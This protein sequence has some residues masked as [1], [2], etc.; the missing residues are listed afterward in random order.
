[1]ATT[2]NQPPQG[3]IWPPAPKGTKIDDWKQAWPKLTVGQLW[4]DSSGFWYQ[5]TAPWGYYGPVIAK[6]QTDLD[7]PYRN[8]AIRASLGMGLGFL[9]GGPA[10]ALIGGGLGYLIGS[11][12]ISSAFGATAKPK[13]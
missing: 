11:R 9:L 5:K 2:S 3:W 7:S 10:G 13:G 8:S 4:E 6:A 1:M 12:P